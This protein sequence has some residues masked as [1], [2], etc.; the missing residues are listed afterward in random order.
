[1]R[2]S[3]QIRANSVV[4]IPVPHPI[5]RISGW[6]GRSVSIENAFLVHSL[7]PGPWRGRPSKMVKMKELSITGSMSYGRINPHGGTAAVPA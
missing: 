7:L 4:C 6:A 5:S 2:Q 1:M 3:G